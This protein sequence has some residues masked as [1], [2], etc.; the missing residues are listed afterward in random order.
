MTAN[1][2]RISAAALL[3]TLAVLR[4]AG[5]DTWLQTYRWQH[6]PGLDSSGF[7]H[8][9][10]SISLGLRNSEVLQKCGVPTRQDTRTERFVLRIGCGASVEQEVDVDEWFYDFGPRRFTR[11]LIF[12]DGRL[13]ATER[14]GYGGGRTGARPLSR[15]RAPRRVVRTSVRVPA[16]PPLHRHGRGCRL[17]Y[18][19]GDSVR[20]TVRPGCR[21]R[22]RVCRRPPRRSRCGGERIVI[23]PW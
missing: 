9:G 10:R 5:A 20:V 1:R 7:Y 8:K 22:R 4:G 12:H 13:V 23:S 3:I 21:T 6:R 19:T 16:H 14:G 11:T 17:R 2:L 15:T 18:E